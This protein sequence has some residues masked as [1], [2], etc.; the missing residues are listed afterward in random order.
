MDKI[1]KEIK[2]IKELLKHVSVDVETGII[3][4]NEDRGNRA[5]AGKEAGTTSVHGYRITSLLVDGK[6][7][8]VRSHRVVYYV[9][10]GCL[11]NEVDHINRVRDDNRINNL[12]SVTSQENSRNRS[13][14]SNNTS[15]V[16]GVGYHKRYKKWRA[17]ITVDYKYIQLGEYEDK[18]DAIKARI[19]AEIKYFGDHSIL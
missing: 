10:H 15:G 1:N 19:E 6:N 16:K 4:W 3:T 13:I 8:W 17:S 11:V 2:E 7:S 9:A 12:R 18:D 5:K 14:A